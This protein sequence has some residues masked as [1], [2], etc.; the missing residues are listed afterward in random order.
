MTDFG[1][2][3]YKWVDNMKDCDAFYGLGELI[4]NDEDIEKLKAGKVLNFGINCDEYAQAIRYQSDYV[5]PDKF[6]N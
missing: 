5:H 4:L 2:C 6:Y 3:T 1:G